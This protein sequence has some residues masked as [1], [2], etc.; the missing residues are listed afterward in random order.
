MSV[1]TSPDITIFANRASIDH[2][3]L[4]APDGIS[5]TKSSCLRTTG[6]RIQTFRALSAQ[7]F[8]RYEALSSSADT[9][10]RDLA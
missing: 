7:M 4:V 2:P 8:V 9:L 1:I 5:L 6:Y 10:C 3:R